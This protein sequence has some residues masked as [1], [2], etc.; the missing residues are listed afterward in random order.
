M[1]TNPNSGMDT[2]KIVSDIGVMQNSLFLY[3][4][5]K[6]SEYSA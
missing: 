4:H 1:G 5:S 6:S 2:L 3:Y